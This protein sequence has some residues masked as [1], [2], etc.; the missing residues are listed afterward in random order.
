MVETFIHAFYEAFYNYLFLWELKKKIIL[1][2][3]PVS[4][5]PLRKVYLVF[6]SSSSLCLLLPEQLQMTGG[7]KR[8]K[9]AKLSFI[10]KS[11]DKG[12]ERKSGLGRKRLGGGIMGKSV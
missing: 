4:L 5:L 11:S 6:A 10:I 9:D 7:G 1:S 8:R 3:F 12:R 2:M